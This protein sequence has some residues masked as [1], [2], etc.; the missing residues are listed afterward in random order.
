[1]LLLRD[2]RMIYDCMTDEE[3]A[4]WRRQSTYAPA[5]SPCLDCPIEFH[6]VEKAAGRCNGTPGGKGRPALVTE[7]RREQWHD[8]RDA[9][10]SPADDDRQ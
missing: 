2:D 8:E 6:L 9:V 5:V 4:L 1:M 7:D 10:R 3:L